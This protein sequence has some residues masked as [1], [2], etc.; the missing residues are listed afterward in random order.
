LDKS[1]YDEI[2]TVPHTQFPECDTL[3][4]HFHRHCEATPD[5]DFLGTRV[6]PQ[7]EKGDFGPYVF[8][9]FKEVDRQSEMI[10]RAIRHLDLS[11][12]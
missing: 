2:E 10:A 5:K 7:E 9:S 6:P 1:L 12:E 4:K 11:P 8:T 3:L